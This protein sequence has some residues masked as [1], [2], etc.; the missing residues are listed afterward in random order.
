MPKP[1]LAKRLPELSMVEQVLLMIF[2]G[3]PALGLWYC[4]DHHRDIHFD[5]PWL[6]LGGHAALIV[7]PLI[8]VAFLFHKPVVYEAG[9]GE[10][11]VGTST[12]FDR[13][14][15]NWWMMF[16]MWATPVFIFAALANA[17]LTRY[18][19]HPENLSTPPGRALAVAVVMFGLGAF[20]AT[21]LLGRSDPATWVSDA[22]LRTS[23]LRFHTWQDI[24]HLSQSGDLY[25][26]Y[27]RVNPALPA[28]AFKVRNREAQALLERHLSAHQIRVTNDSHPSFQLV[29]F[30]V[31]FGFLGNVAF[32][33]WLRFNT[34]LS[35]LAVVLISFCGGI[36]LTALLERYRGV[37]KYGKF[38]PIIEP[39]NEA[40]TGDAPKPII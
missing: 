26:F 19:A 36:V 32:S 27:H 31:I 23:I 11:I 15:V 25:A 9:D 33:L 12:Y 29:K 7:L 28:N 35:F 34:S 18:L 24:H 5:N 21:L 13:W 20:Y 4:W 10:T 38:M 39:A 16:M 22:G 3:L 6:N 8:W 1:L 2:V 40:Q 14:P 17:F 30:G 37:S